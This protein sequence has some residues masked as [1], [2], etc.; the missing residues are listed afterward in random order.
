MKFELLV[1]ANH[2]YIALVLINILELLAL[3]ILR[4]WVSLQH[5][6]LGPPDA[7]G[8]ASA[9]H[10]HIDLSLVILKRSPVPF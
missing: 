2:S 9:D 5:D 10:T 1:V 3:R 6:F 7:S 4:F 8:A